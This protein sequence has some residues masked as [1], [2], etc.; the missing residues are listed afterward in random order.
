M[1]SLPAKTVLSRL[2]GLRP[3]LPRAVVTASV[4]GVAGAGLAFRLLRAGD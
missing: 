2:V 1:A 4:V 3:P